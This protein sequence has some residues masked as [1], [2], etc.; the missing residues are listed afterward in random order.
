MLH[1]RISEK[2]MKYMKV[3]LRK[4][5]KISNFLFKYKIMSIYLSTKS[6][7]IV[8]QTKTECFF[9]LKTHSFLLYDSYKKNFMI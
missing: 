7:A 9:P 1:Y 5:T 6:S 4:H 2:R 8:V 3:Q